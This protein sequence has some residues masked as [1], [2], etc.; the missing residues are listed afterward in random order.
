M[1]TVLNPLH[2]KL[3]SEANKT[4]SIYGNFVVYICPAAAKSSGKNSPKARLAQSKMFGLFYVSLDSSYET[5][6]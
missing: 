6:L 4:P 2:N 3:F 5:L 1:H